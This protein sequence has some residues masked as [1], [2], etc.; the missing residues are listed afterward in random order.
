MKKLSDKEYNQLW[1]EARNDPQFKKD[2]Q[3]FIKMSTSVYRLK[4]FKLLE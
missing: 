2:I 4:D 1:E 3:A